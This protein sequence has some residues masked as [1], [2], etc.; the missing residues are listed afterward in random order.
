MSIEHDRLFSR[1]EGIL[2]QY[3]SFSFSSYFLE[4]DVDVLKK[5]SWP[6][7]G[8]KSRLGRYSVPWSIFHMI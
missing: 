3:K 1:P 7:L 4:S 5:S 2:K 6:V 8:Q